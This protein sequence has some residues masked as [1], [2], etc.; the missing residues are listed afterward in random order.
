MHTLL[1]FSKYFVSLFYFMGCMKHGSKF[2]N[3]WSKIFSCFKKE[4]CPSLA[5]SPLTTAIYPWVPEGL[6]PRG[7]RDWNQNYM[8]HLENNPDKKIAKRKW[9]STNLRLLPKSYFEIFLMLTLLDCQNQS[10]WQ[11]IIFKYTIVCNI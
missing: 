11:W 3:I 4:F 2:R 5:L 8:E 9:K 7:R 1:V 6:T 10:V